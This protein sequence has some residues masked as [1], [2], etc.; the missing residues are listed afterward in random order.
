MTDQ[1]NA[2]RLRAEYITR[3]RRKTVRNVCHAR[4]N[5]NG[6]D[7]CDVYSGPGLDCWK[8]NAAHK[9]LFV[10]EEKYNG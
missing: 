7:Y 4:P 9:C 10:R 8:Q 6:C 3:S 2:E 1:A 5:W